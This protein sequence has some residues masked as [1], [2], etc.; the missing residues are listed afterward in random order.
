MSKVIDEFR[1]KQYAVLRLDEMPQKTYRKYR[2]ANIEFEPV[3]LYDMPQCIA[4]QSE[5]DF[6]G[7]TV[8]FI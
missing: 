6:T 3:P 2:I 7:K 5:A 4:I 1:V 8:E